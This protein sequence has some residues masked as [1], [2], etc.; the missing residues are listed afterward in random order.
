MG[1]SEGIF[2]SER[3]KILEEWGAM[4]WSNTV[5]SRGITNNSIIPVKDL[6]H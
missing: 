4:R 6:R 1:E 5:L 2:S 3:K